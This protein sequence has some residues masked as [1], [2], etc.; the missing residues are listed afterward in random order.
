MLGSIMYH[1]DS[2]LVEYN[3]LQ[4]S[5]VSLMI[6]NVLQYCWVE[7][8]FDVTFGDEFKQIL[9]TFLRKGLPT[10]Y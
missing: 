9:S 1:C 4:H 7:E 5:G 6:K 2:D 3:E 10:N 8:D